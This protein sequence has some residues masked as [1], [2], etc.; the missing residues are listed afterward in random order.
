MPPLVPRPPSSPRETT[1][2]GTLLA[3][4]A[5]ISKLGHRVLQEPVELHVAVK[6]SGGLF[7]EVGSVK[8]KRLSAFLAYPDRK[9][10]ANENLRLPMSLSCTAAH[11]VSHGKRT[12]LSWLK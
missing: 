12:H 1:Q 6:Q 4:R 10:A 9:H 11:R 3:L 8:K 7:H 5:L 2:A